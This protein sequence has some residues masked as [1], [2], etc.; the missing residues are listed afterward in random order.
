M[1]FRSTAALTAFMSSDE[2]GRSG[3]KE[4][5]HIITEETTSA[6]REALIRHAATSNAVTLVSQPL[7]YCVCA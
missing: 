2:Y 1:F 7:N 6:E 5:V 4:Q 3:L